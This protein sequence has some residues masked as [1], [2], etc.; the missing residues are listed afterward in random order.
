MLRGKQHAIFRPLKTAAWVLFCVRGDATVTDKAAQDAWYR[1]QLMA[2]LG[3]YS[4]K[5]LATAADFDALCLHFATLADDDGQIAYWSGADERRAMYRLG[6]TMRN[7]RVDWGYITGI[8]RKMK[9]IAADADPA[10]TKAALAMLPA[11]HILKIN[12]AV[13]IHWKRSQKRTKGTAHE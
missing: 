13:F 5:Q 9:L 4:T 7:A 12:T 2:S 10:G 6:I 11:A 8:A 1:K 3:V